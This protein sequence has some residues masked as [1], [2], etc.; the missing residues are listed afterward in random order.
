MSTTA[1]WDVSYTSTATTTD[2]IDVDG[3]DWGTAVRAERPRDHHQPPDEYSI[4]YDPETK[5]FVVSRGWD[6]A[7]KEFS[8]KRSA[9]RFVK[10]WMEKKHGIKP[11]K[12]NILKR[13]K[14]KQQEL[15]VRKEEERK[16][17]EYRIEAERVAERYR[18][19]QELAWAVQEK[20]RLKYEEEQEEDNYFERLG[21]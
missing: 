14:E 9:Q 16:A 1:T 12:T 20:A 4:T 19:S 15:K 13:L 5:K 11:S 2:W 10:R 21:I 18:K 6:Y 8:T 7:D 3:M 17:E